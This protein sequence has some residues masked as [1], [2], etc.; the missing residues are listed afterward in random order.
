MTR[1][2]FPA[3]A[4]L[5]ATTLSLAVLAAAAPPTP[6]ASESA[7]PSPARLAAVRDY[8]R[9]SWTTLSRSLADLPA[10]ARDP[11]VHLEKGK[12]WPVYIAGREDQATIE[13]QLKRTLS[14]ADLATIEIRL[15]PA[16]L[17]Q[18]REAGLLYLPRP[19]VVPGGRFNE[20]YGWDSYF[21]Q[22]GL[23]RD[24]ELAA[25]RDMTDNFIYEIANYGTLLN[26]NRTY[27]LTR[28][29]PPFLSR[30]VLDVYQKDLN[31]AW[32]RSA[33]PA[34]VKYYEFWIAEPHLV[35]VT[36]LS[37]YFDTGDGPAPE[38]ESDEKDAEGRTHY[39]RAREYYK[40]HEVTDYDVNRFYDRQKDSLH[41]LFYKGDRSMRESGFDPSN[42]FGPFSVDIIH[43]VPVCLNSLLYQMEK[44]GAEIART[45][46]DPA[47]AITW[48]A[49]A[50]ERLRRID[51]YLWDEQAGLYL[52]YNFETKKRRHYEFATTFYP[53]WAGAASKQQAARVVKNLPRFEAPGGILTSTQTTGNQWDAP[54]GW[55][56][57]QLIAVE[58]LRRYGYH[59]EA[60]RIARKFIALVTKEFEEHGTIVEK[61]DLKRRES[62][63]AADIKFGY[64]ANQVGFGWTNGVFVEL[65]EGL[66]RSRAGAK[67]AARLG[68]P[69]SGP[70]TA[71]GPAAI[72]AAPAD[73]PRPSP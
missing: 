56:P 51:Q 29:Q 54:F 50:R 27:Y 55:A 5:A 36:G 30:M 38:V 17:S 10:A 41:P 9:K 3:A 4:A 15:L 45:L 69:V 59:A 16:W 73:P 52:D 18:I 31:R 8:I 53:L 40:T 12:A 25:A 13:A 1:R 39:D 67:P 6:A 7:L 64:S 34:V 32:L 11:K 61:Y 70:R 48:E 58:G 72:P 20:M 66:E 46:A 49:R 26:A 42:R 43:H 21:I 35:P 24:G 22:L 47:V 44:D 23:L 71:A 19:Y 68:A 2:P 33:L 62:D 63:V 14:P 57:L 60:D 37:R 65:L 28:S